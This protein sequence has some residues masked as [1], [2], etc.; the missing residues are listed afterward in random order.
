MPDGRINNGNLLQPQELPELTLQTNDQ[1]SYSIHSNRGKWT[2]LMLAD[3][4][5]NKQ[6]KKNVYLMRQVRTSLGKDSHNTER[7]LI[8]SDAPVSASLADFLLD[9][10][11]ML[12]VTAK[13]NDVQTL[14][15]FLASI[16]GGSLNKL[17]L[18]DPSGKVMMHYEPELQPKDLLSDLKRLIMVNSN[19]VAG[20]TN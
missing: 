19:D 9:Y 7:L 11:D 17:F 12:V 8:I 20:N 10:P 18:I 14:K 16:A 1:Q 15:T 2:L 4:S 3:S 6:C 5:C 13:Q